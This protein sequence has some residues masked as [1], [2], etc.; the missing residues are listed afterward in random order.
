MYLLFL[1][2][3][4][5]RQRKDVIKMRRTFAYVLNNI[6]TLNIYVTLGYIL[7]NYSYYVAKIVH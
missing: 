5:F 4:L 7:T 1:A 6:I 3:V 2:I